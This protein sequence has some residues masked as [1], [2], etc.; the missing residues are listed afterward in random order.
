MLIFVI[1]YI[2]KVWIKLARLLDFENSGIFLK[3]NTQLS[4]TLNI[5]N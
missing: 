4:N 5:L 3:N 1:E 2:K